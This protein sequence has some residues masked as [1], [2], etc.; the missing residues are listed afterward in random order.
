MSQS[1]ANTNLTIWNELKRTDPKATKPFQRSGGFKGTQID[2][3]YR[4]ERMTEVFGPVGQGWGWEQT[5]QHVSDGMVFVGVRVWYLPAG[6]APKWP[7]TAP[8]VPL[9][10]RFTGPQWGGDVLTL[11]RGGRTRP[12]DEAFKM[13]MTD[14]IGKALLSIGLAADVYMGLFDDS[15]YREESEAFYAAKSNPALQPEAIAEFET[16]TK[17]RVDACVDLDDLD[18]V[19]RGG[20]GT[21]L[22]EISRIDAYAQKRVL[23]LF[24]RRKAELVKDEQKTSAPPPVQI[25]PVADPITL[26]LA[27]GEVKEFRRTV[28]G[29]EAYFK[30]LDDL[31]RRDR[32]LWKANAPTAENLSADLMTPAPDVARMLDGIKA[33]LPEGKKAPSPDELRMAG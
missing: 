17:K 12:N 27:E 13:A 2:P 26:F 22:R 31:V 33:M 16:Q 15:K 4:M 19:W 9:N 32:F 11:E 30:E 7:E 21:R 20:V 18:E 1:D 6:E 28:K 25:A 23:D 3:V 29:A 8:G 5:G 24:S 10:A 14:A